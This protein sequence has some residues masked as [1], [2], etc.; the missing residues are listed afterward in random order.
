MESCII[1]IWY[2]RRYQSKDWRESRSRKKPALYIRKTIRILLQWRSKNEY[3]GVILEIFFEEDED[4]PGF[5]IC[6]Y[7]SAKRRGNYWIWPR[8]RV[9]KTPQSTRG[10]IQVRKLKRNRSSWKQQWYLQF[11]QNYKSANSRY[12]ARWK[13]K[14][15]TQGKKP[16]SKIGIDYDMQ[17]PPVP[18]KR[19]LKEILLLCR[20]VPVFT[21]AAKDVVWNTKRYTQR[22]PNLGGRIKYEDLKKRGRST[23]NTTITW[24]YIFWL[25][26]QFI[27]LQSCLKEHEP[28]YVEVKLTNIRKV[29]A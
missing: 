2:K 16:Y 13:N 24:G 1:I 9:P 10:P 23:G 6:I 25:P 19:S 12:P 29:I 21:F 28:E 17:P 4:V 27:P 8:E 18:W 14:N 11:K 7:Y 15:F 22:V 26:L 3:D 5:A 20:N